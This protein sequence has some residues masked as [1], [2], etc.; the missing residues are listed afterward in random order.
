MALAHPISIHRLARMPFPSDAILLQAALP[1]ERARLLEMPRVSGNLARR[2]R[3]SFA[4]NE[5]NAGE[6]SARSPLPEKDLPTL[7][8]QSRDKGIDRLL[9]QSRSLA[10]QK[11]KE[12]GLRNE[13]T[14]RANLKAVLRHR[15]SFEP[16]KR[17]TG[18]KA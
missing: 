9:A 4:S 13:C 2:I 18:G 17:K 6:E 11:V 14:G 8:G 5:P 10:A 16:S 1:V 12:L 3:E 7:R 15:A